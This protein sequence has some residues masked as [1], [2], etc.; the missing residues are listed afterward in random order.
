MAYTRC[1]IVPSIS[2]DASMDR[3]TLLGLVVATLT[4]SPAATRA[5]GKPYRIGIT[6]HTWETSEMAGAEPRGQNVKAFLGGLH[7]LGYV[8][9][10]HFV[11]EV[12]GGHGK[13][14]RYPAVAA[15]L[16]R[17]RVD[18]IVSSGVMLAPLKQATSTIPIVMAAAS[19]PVAEGFVQNLARPGTNFT[20][21]S[22]PFRAYTEAGGLI[23]RSAD[24]G[25]IWRRA[26]F[27]VDKILKGA[28]PADLPVEQPTKFELVINMKAARA[29]GL[30]VPPSLLLQADQ[31]IE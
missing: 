23:S 20:G 31:I 13:P 5:A 11:T 1:V 27:F 26:A 9:G 18:V 25:A 12:R 10:Q 7:D 19:D 29:L 21:L 22:Y 2:R 15:E 4:V 28:R 24:L 30:T 3:R 17:L 8:Y 14:E 6:S 16:V